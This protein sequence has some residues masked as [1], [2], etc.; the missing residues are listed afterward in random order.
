MG[1]LW[2]TRT[3]TLLEFSWRK[4]WSRKEQTLF[5]LSMVIFSLKSKLKEDIFRETCISRW[6]LQCQWR[7]PAWEMHQSQVISMVL[8]INL[9]DYLFHNCVL[10]FLFCI[11]KS[12]LVCFSYSVFSTWARSQSTF[13]A[14]YTSYQLERRTCCICLQSYFLGGERSEYFAVRIFV[15]QWEKN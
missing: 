9:L 12:V 13:P 15:S 7:P 2:T 3:K 8:G 1:F 11:W 5:L 6:A 14:S 4:C 10:L